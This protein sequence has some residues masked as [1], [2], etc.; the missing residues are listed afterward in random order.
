MK[1]P[2]LLSR[3]PE[4]ERKS[5]ELDRL[6]TRAIAVD[7]KAERIAAE[8]HQLAATLRGTVKALRAAPHR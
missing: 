4:R 1:W 3:D 6:E 7:E 5:L 2:S 8:S